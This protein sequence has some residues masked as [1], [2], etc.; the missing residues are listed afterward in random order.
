MEKLDQQNPRIQSKIDQRIQQSHL[1]PM[2]LLRKLLNRRLQWHS[3][4]WLL[5]PPV[6]PVK[7]PY[8]AGAT[9][10]DSKVYWV[11]NCCILPSFIRRLSWISLCWFFC[12][13]RSSLTLCCTSCIYWVPK[14]TQKAYSSISL[15][16]S[17]ISVVCFGNIEGQ[18]WT[19]LLLW[20]I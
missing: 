15:L 16:L 20:K 14:G 13:F 1:D 19:K 9:D 6:E 8:R 11:L 10:S 5:N 2:I 17:F 12:F 4:F 18:S 3:F 7:K